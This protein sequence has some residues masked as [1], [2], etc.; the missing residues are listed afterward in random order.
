MLMGKVIF[1]GI[2]P[3]GNLHIGNYIGALKQWIKLQETTEA[4][5]CIVDLHA[6]TVYQDPKVLK[7]KIREVTALYL[8]CGVDHNKAHIFAQSE[9]PDHTY[10]A[11]ILDCITP[12]GLLS[13]MTQ[14][15]EKSRKASSLKGIGDVAKEIFDS[16]LSYSVGL[17]N[18]PALMAADILLYDTDQ[19]PVGEDQKQH[20]EFTR[21]IAEKFNKIYG[22]IFKLPEPLIQKATARIMSLQNPNSKMSKSDKDTAGTINL[23]DDEQ[24]VREKVKKAVTDSGTDI[25]KKEDKPAM[26]NL[27]TIYESVSGISVSELEQKYKG[28]TY[29]EFKNDLAQD[30]I[31][32]LLPIQ[33]KYKRI[34]SDSGYLDMVLNEGKDYAASISSKKILQVKKAVGLER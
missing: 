1:S 18:Y 2:Q 33:E 22:N 25:L 4:I 12:F 15:K 26:S 32:F 30:I 17:F 20:I 7:E 5:F 27:L 29:S 6:I 10:L 14:F 23:L 8:A 3:S 11:W 31:N 9:N 13:R 16:Q 19:V 34:R 28:K 24:T 21:D